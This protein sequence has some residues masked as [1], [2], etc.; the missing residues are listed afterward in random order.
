MSRPAR[1]HDRWSSELQSP[2]SAGGS[3]VTD[4]ARFS[5]AKPRI[6][7]LLGVHLNFTSTAQGRSLPPLASRNS[8]W[9][10]ILEAG[11]G[12]G[13]GV[14]LRCPTAAASPPARR[15][16]DRPLRCVRRV[17]RERELG[18]SSIARSCQPPNLRGRRRVARRRRRRGDI[19]DAAEI[20]VRASGITTARR[21][22]RAAWSPYSRR[23]SSPVTSP[24]SRRW[25]PPAPM[26]QGRPAES[27]PAMKPMP[28]CAHRPGM[29]F[30][31]RCCRSSRVSQ[32]VEC[33]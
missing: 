30:G 23:G 31:Q 16:R 4:C 29:R 14:V 1:R 22:T 6:R 13:W 17:A 32:V 7:A 12:D 21:S 20:E 11:H 26:A 9:R 2:E 10:R 27:R 28:S 24:V 33:T 3:A 25:L 8:G 5:P 19:V 18:T 15:E